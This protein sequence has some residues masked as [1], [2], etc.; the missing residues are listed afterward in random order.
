[1][2][3]PEPPPRGLQR[4]LH[5]DYYRT[6]AAFARERE[7]I[8]FRDWFCLARE[9]EV[10]GAGDWLA[11]D[12]AGESVLLVRLPDGGLAAHYNVCRHR[13]S[14]LVPECGAGHFAAGIRCPY[15]SWTYHLD[16]RLRT[17]P[18]LDE[19]DG[20][21]PETLALHRVEVACWG[22][23]VF[24]RLG[25][26]EA[27]PTLAQQ[28]GGAPER[29]R[30]YPL[31]ELRVAHR[32]VYPVAANWKVI[33]ENYNECYHCG[34][35][36]PEL[37]R[38]VPA[39]KQRGGSELDWERGIPH[40]D[41]AWT[42]TA[43]GTTTRAPFPGLDPDE[44]VRHKGELIYPNLLLSLSADHVAAFRLRPEAPER[45]TVVC[46]FL[47][48]PYEIA[49]PGF[50]PSDAVEFWDRVNR[51]DWT[52]CESVQRGMGSRRF[53]TGFYAPME[54]WSLDI[55]RYVGER[56]GLAPDELAEPIR[57]ATDEHGG[58]RMNDTEERHRR[59]KGMAAD[60]R[61]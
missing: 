49:R 51:Q 14:R 13:G 41:G 5:R 7:R 23:F 60:E 10:A 22:G 59:T 16:G 19:G 47:F 6:E 12:V 25:S 24:V 45:T 36:H 61:R 57:L 8:F 32:I 58:T 3:A 11:R 9:E 18:Y 39:F 29:V 33:L 2:T 48:H 15:H 27:G 30:R 53:T 4:T 50:D 35:V 34:P 26:E 52:I 54:S 40:R 21:D 43:S 28:V 37:C 1:M 20:V 17:A 38:L 44:Q 55:R 46:E 31:A 42:F 56:L